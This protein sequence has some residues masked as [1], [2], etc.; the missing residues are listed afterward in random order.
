MSKLV[1]AT[2]T[3]IDQSEGLRMALLSGLSFVLAIVFLGM[4]VSDQARAAG[5]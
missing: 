2:R 5:L 4:L 1:V 3:R